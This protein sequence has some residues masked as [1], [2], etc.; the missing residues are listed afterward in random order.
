MCNDDRNRRLILSF[1]KYLRHRGRR[2]VLR[3]IGALLKAGGILVTICGLLTF[4]LANMDVHPISSMFWGVLMTCLGL[5]MLFAG[6]NV[7]KQAN[8]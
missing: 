8:R 1:R 6:H 4:A 7:A 3:I 2:D 5:L